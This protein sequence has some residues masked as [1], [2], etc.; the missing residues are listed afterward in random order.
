MLLYLMISEHDP[1]HSNEL[2][3][4]IFGCI[5][6][7]FQTNDNIMT[8]KFHEGRDIFWFYGLCVLKYATNDNIILPFGKESLY[9]HHMHICLHVHF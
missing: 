9:L 8:L 6:Y 5:F 1:C 4:N 7:S 3:E 2:C